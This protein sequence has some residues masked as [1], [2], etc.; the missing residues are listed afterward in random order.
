MEYQD[1]ELI[2]RSQMGD[3]RAFNVLVE[4]Y[5]KETLKVAVRMI[6]SLPDA[7]D[8]CQNSWLAAWKSIHSFR[9]GSFRAWVLRIVANACR[10]IFRRKKQ[11]PEILGTDSLLQNI[12]DSNTDAILSLEM[13]ETIQKA[14]IRLPHKQRLAVTL[15]EFNGLSYE[16]IAMV[17]KCSLGTVRS[18]LNRGRIN[19]RNLLQ[20]KESSE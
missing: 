18:R 10:D 16:E 6:G 2:R 4:R 14:L 15:R 3:L 1:N 8:V 7:E 19:L 20:G 17:M 5:Q 12:A 11:L 13:V 9:G